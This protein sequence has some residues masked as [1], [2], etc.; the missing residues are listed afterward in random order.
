MIESKGNTKP[1]KEIDDFLQETPETKKF[2]IYVIRSTVL[3]EQ[4][5][6]PQQK[7]LISLS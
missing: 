1:F 5:L 2:E 3:L 6:K 4:N 7:M